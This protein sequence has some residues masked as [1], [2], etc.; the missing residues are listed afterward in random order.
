MAKGVR[1]GGPRGV[2]WA[3][4]RSGGRAS[5]PCSRKR[6][7]ET[8]VRRAGAGLLGKATGEVTRGRRQR[9]KGVGGLGGGAILAS[10]FP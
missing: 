3:V 1:L 4:G 6:G 5:Y 8:G 10:S 7:G 9:E 2:A